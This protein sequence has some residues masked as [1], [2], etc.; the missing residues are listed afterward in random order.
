M[1][2]KHNH[3]EPPDASAGYEKSDASIGALLQFGFW[4]AVLIT[5]TIFAMAWAFKYFS[6]ITPLGQPAAPS[7]VVNPNLR[8]LPPSPR[9]Q[10][11]PHEELVD[12]CRQQEQE[13]NTY[14]WVD[15]EAGI[16]RVPISRAMDLV[17]AQ[18]LP[19]RAAGEA[20]K[21]V[22]AADPPP[23]TVAGGD[24]IQGPCAYLAPPPAGSGAHAEK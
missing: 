20:P 5:V 1:E 22:A 6:R 4:L 17:L 9:L 15:R 8:E 18:G 16:V 23:P 21:G 11:L 13:V 14:G 12:Y 24:E 2:T 7:A 19:T 10:P 3:T